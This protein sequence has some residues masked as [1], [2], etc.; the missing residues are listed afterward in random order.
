[1]K[2]DFTKYVPSANVPLTRIGDISPSKKAICN[3]LGVDTTG[4]TA[5]QISYFF[6]YIGVCEKYGST[7]EQPLAF[8]VDAVAGPG[9]KPV[10]NPFASELL[11]LLE[12]FL[13][14]NDKIAPRIISRMQSAPRH[15]SR[16]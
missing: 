8:V 2:T 4:L 11:A 3:K 5:E 15:P 1:M 14:G 10:D 12:E 7:D 6:I 9:G 13:E 16:R